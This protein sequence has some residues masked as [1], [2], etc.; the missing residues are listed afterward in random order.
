MRADVQTFGW[1]KACLASAFLQ[2]IEPWE[3]NFLE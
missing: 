2:V 1:I 3:S